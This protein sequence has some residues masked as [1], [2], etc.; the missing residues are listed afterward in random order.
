MIR[1][2]KHGI[3][4]AGGGVDDDNGD[5]RQA[6]ANGRRLERPAQLLA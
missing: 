5:L 3:G 4:L 1:A 6:K 2:N